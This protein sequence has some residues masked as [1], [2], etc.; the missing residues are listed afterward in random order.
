MIGEIDMDSKELG[1]YALLHLGV[2][3]ENDKILDIVIAS[4][5]GKDFDD[6]KDYKRAVKGEQIFKENFVEPDYYEGQL[7]A[8]AIKISF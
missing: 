3:M 5:N 8:N 1:L 6:L 2:E 4:L 7:L